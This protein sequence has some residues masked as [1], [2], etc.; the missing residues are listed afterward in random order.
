MIIKV[1][2]T[3]IVIEN[4]SD[5]EEGDLV[6]IFSTVCDKID[7]EQLASFEVFF[8]NLDER[9]KKLTFAY[10]FES[11]APELPD[12]EI[13]LK[14]K[15]EEYE[16]FF[17]ESDR[18]VLFT[19]NDDIVSFDILDTSKTNHIA[20]GNISLKDLVQIVEK[21]NNDFR[22]LLDRCF[23]KAFKIFEKENY[24]IKKAENRV[25]SPSHND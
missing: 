25:D 23:P 14:R 2:H 19:I 5:L 9:F 20:N 21:L 3:D 12:F 16:L 10:D 17:Y 13:F 8:D 7:T 1:K 24:L 11:I 6:S 15:K 22:D 18:R 4:Y